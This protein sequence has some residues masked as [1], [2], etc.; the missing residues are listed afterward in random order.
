MRIGK[1][2]PVLALVAAALAGC[3]GVASGT[4]AELVYWASQQGAGPGDDREILQPEL[5]K[6][7]KQTGVK[8]RVEVVP[9]TELLDR[10]REAS[11]SGQGP[12]VV[13]IDTTWSASLQATGAF[14]PFDDAAL[15]KVGGRGRF[16]GPPLAATGAAGRPPVGVP[17]YGQAYGL[18]YNKRLFKEAG[19]AGP[20]KTWDELIAAGR[21]LT[22]PEK[23]R[24][25]LSLQAGRPT[26]NSRLAAILGAQQGAEFFTPDGGPRLASGPSVEAVRQ[27][28]DLMQEHR[29]VN[30]S[31]A[32][33]T[34]PARSIKDLA[35]GRAAMFMHQASGR[36]FQNLGMAMGDLG[37][38][39][40]PL[41]AAPPA[42]GRKV[43]SF[44]GGIN[45]S[46]FARTGNRDAALDLVRFLVSTPE[47]ALLNKAYGSLPTV[48]DAYADPA[49]RTEEAQVFRN[50]LSSTAEPLPQVPQE[51]RSETLLG[52]AI[53][54]MFAD[55]SA[56]GSVGA[57]QIRQALTRVDE[58]LTAG[59]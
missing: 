11:V 39:P 55:V 31:D 2:G 17:L 48:R 28:V 15:A 27:Y 32:A 7:E 49:F 35:D 38:A 57:G 1:F 56:G 29:I 37:V 36:S 20:P 26:A 18:Y 43:T 24:W 30:P 50:I 52:T 19:I 42:N 5:D 6:F 22:D 14:L 34:D 40:I 9:W 41:P 58:R 44:V 33:S 54:R 51:P 47:Q 45:L 3:G 4:R 12:D 16:L 21:K 59:G 23:G 8:V 10:I 25:G 46:V 13:N 53:Q